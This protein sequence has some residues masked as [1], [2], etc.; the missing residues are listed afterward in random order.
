MAERPHRGRSTKRVAG[1]S[2]AQ[3]PRNSWSPRRLRTTPST[4]SLTSSHLRRQGR[5]AASRGPARGDVRRPRGAAATRAALPVQ[6]PAAG[7][8]STPNA[9]RGGRRLRGRAVGAQPGGFPAEPDAPT[10]GGQGQESGQD[11]GASSP[12]G[13]TGHG[14]VTRSG[15]GGRRGDAGSRAPRPGARQALGRARRRRRDATALVEAGAAAYGVD[16]TVILDIIHVVEY[17]W[18]ARTFREAPTRRMGRT[19][20]QSILEG[21]S[22]KVAAMRRAASRAC[23]ATPA[24]RSIRRR[25]PAEVRAVSALRPLLAAGYPI[26]TVVPVPGPRPDGLTGARW[27]LVGAEA[28]PGAT[29]QRRLRMPGTSTKRR[30]RAE[31]LQRYADGIAPP[32][33]DRPHRP[34]HLAFAGSSIAMPLAAPPGRTADAKEPHPSAFRCICGLVNMFQ[35]LTRRAIGALRAMCGLSGMIGRPERLAPAC[36]AHAQDVVR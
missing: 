24:S 31:P 6:P 12:G 9:W 28:V 26:A 22:S 2:G 36:T 14:R 35:L 32:V 23:R 30:V 27:R 7:R 16:V 4:P 33:S 19:R 3:V 10:A 34:P 15:R 25:L 17:V 8:R 20:V 11:R 21:K 1:H 13:Q 29:G 5:G 18:K